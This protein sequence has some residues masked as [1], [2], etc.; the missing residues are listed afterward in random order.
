MTQKK[1]IQQ[2]STNGKKVWS[3][4]FELLKSSYIKKLDIKDVTLLGINISHQNSV[5][6]MIFLFPRWDMWSFPGGYFWKR[7]VTHWRRA[8][9]LWSANSLIS[10]K[11]KCLAVSR[12]VM[13]EVL[14][15]LS[16]R[17][18]HIHPRK[19]TWNLKMNPWKRRFLWTTIIFRFHV[20]FLGC[21]YII[22]SIWK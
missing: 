6:K 15:S 2:T 9:Q 7:F 19:L 18:Y 20:S 5:L 12:E 3:F 13:I 21:I 17:T 22:S 14:R 8:T 10:D 1:V 16:K 11:Q 4:F